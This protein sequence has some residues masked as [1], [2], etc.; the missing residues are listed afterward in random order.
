MLR[1]IFEQSQPVSA[2]FRNAVS[3]LTEGNPFFIE[4][5]LKALLSAG[6]IFMRDGVWDRKPVQQL[7]IPRSVQ[8]A[9]EQR[10]AQLEAETRQLTCLAAVIGRRFS[11]RLLQALLAIDEQ[12]LLVHLKHLVAAQIIV[13]ETVEVYAFRHALTREAVYATLL[14]RERRLH[15]RRIAEILERQYEHQLDQH[16]ADLAHHYAQAG[17]WEQV[18]AYAQ[19]AGDRARAMYAPREAAALYA[20][21]FKAAEHLGQPPAAEL[22]RARGQAYETLGEFELARADYERALTSG[23]AVGAGPRGVAVSDRPGISVGGARL[24]ACG[25]A[26]SSGAQPG[27]GTG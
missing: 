13:E 17:E 19:R 11:F 3:T 6:D 15:H 12:A 9:V 23:A 22:F 5:V 21:A 25:R 16:V 24:H 2:E 26:F 4:E 20:R 14:R 10:L 27:A 8:L 1:A 7:S 18:L